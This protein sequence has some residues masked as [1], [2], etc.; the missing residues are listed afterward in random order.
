MLTH[1]ANAQLNNLVSLRLLVRLGA[2]GTLLTGST[3]SLRCN[4]TYDTA[5][6]VAQSV[7]FDLAE[8]IWDFEEGA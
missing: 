4:I 1:A 8:W 6:A 3:N 7:G 2:P 5:F